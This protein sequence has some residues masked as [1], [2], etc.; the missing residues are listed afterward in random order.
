MVI[1]AMSPAISVIASFRFVPFVAPV[2][3]PEFGILSDSNPNP[4]VDVNDPGADA[5]TDAS[6][7][8]TNSLVFVL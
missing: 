2:P 4:N 5:D 3:M 1:N 8:N 6:P 7:L